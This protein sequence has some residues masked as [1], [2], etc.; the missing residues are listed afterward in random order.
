MPERPPNCR[1][2]EIACTIS[3]MH[4]L[5]PKL[6]GKGVYMHRMCGAGTG[7]YRGP[8][9][10]G[11]TGGGGQNG[12]RMTDAWV[13]ACGPGPDCRI[14]SAL[15]TTNLREILDALDH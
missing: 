6:A 11:G 1:N 9:E 5:S 10:G 3:E 13:E 2:A 15:Q 14:K 7:G 8:R 4:A 12:D